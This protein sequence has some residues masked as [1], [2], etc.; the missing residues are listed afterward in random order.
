[1]ANDPEIPTSAQTPV[2]TQKVSQLDSAQVHV[3]SDDQ[4]RVQFNINELM[5]KIAPASA[6]THCSGCLGCMG[7]KV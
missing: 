2:S 3:T 1:M 7:C 5:S 4:L 6:E